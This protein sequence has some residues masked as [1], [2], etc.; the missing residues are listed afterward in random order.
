M[1]K[2]VEARIKEGKFQN[3]VICTYDN[4]EVIPEFRYFPDEITFSSEE[5]LHMTQDEVHELFYRRDR[6]YLQS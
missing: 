5:F 1:K 2:V 6:A 3:T 4:G